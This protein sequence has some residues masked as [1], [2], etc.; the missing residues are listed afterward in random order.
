MIHFKTN[1]CV[2]MLFQNLYNEKFSEGL[3]I[4]QVLRETSQPLTFSTNELINQF[5]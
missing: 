3:S 1:F 2:A 5:T 4:H